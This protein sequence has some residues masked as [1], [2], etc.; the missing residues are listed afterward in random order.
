[1]KYR[2]II[3]LNQ[4]LWHIA[5]ND[6]CGTLLDTIHY[7]DNDLVAYAMILGYL[8]MWQ[9]NIE[10]HPNQS[11]VFWSLIKINAEIMLKGT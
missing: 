5:V 7:A 2:I 8:T 4:G 10:V 9:G 1:M 6:R 11:N 3:Q